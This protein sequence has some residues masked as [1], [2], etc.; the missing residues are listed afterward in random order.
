MRLHFLRRKQID[1]FTM[2][3]LIVITTVVCILLA[4]L[5]SVAIKAHA[6]Q[7]RISCTMHLKV[8]GASYLFSSN[9]HRNPSTWQIQSNLAETNFS[10]LLRKYF[11]GTNQVNPRIFAC[12][13]DTRKPATNLAVI[14]RTNVSYFISLNASESLPQAFLAGDR[15][16]MTNGVQV[17]PG[18]ANLTAQ[19]KVS[20]DGTMHR[21]Q[22]HVL[23]GDG[24]IQLLGSTRLQDQWTNQGV[25][26]I[27]FAVP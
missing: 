18:I 5:I 19:S 1:A 8:V 20:W 11:A 9:E 22:G 24:S 16:I 26:S 13:A 6:K 3:E 21:F 10:E 27:T 4:L 15:N 25:S 23:M 17:E 14:T 12:P 7:Q 2:L